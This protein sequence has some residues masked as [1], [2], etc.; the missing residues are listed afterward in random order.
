MDIRDQY[1]DPS[2]AMLYHLLH[3]NPQAADYVKQ[4]ELDITQAEQ[5][6]DGEFA[7][8]QRRLFPINTPH[9]TV[10]SCLYRQKC[11]AVPADV[12]DRLKS[13][14][15]IYDV[16][17]VVSAT[18]TAQAAPVA[19]VPEDYL[20]PHLR[21]LRI[22]TAAD[23]PVAEKLLLEQYPRLGIEDRAEAFVNLVKKAQEYQTPLKPHTY[24]MAGM[25]VCTTKTA[26]DFIEARRCATNQPLL[27]QAY[28]KLASTLQGR[29]EFI[30]D[31][32]ALVNLADALTKLDKQAGLE[33]HYDKRLPDPI[34]TVFNTDKL[35]EPMIDLAGRSVGLSKLAALPSTF[36]SDVVGPDMIGDITDAAGR[37]DIE[38]LGQV[39]PT[40]PLDLRIILRHQ[41]PQ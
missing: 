5:L 2:F 11:A 38:K 6:S 21:R 8:P 28:E 3:Q 13:A 30:Q 36:W 27:Q 32:D 22:K 14:V 24:R 17:A 26:M 37:I 31:R 41:V 39:L 12:D 33:K 7:W 10:L 9:N 1:H 23:V 40:L 29:G 16:D 18:K 15:Q 19:D 34:Q 20:L 25:T 35:A 4:A